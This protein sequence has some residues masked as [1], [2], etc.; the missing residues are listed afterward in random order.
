MVQVVSCFDTIVKPHIET[1]VKRIINRL[2][3]GF[4]TEIGIYLKKVTDIK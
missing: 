2:S 4:R 3:P 1:L